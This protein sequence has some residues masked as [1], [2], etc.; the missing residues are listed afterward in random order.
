[1][2]LGIGSDHAGYAA[3]EHLKRWLA[4]RGHD[5]EDVGTHGTA[6]VDYPDYAGQVGRLVAS[7]TVQLGLLICGTGI[8]M[9]IA[10]NKVKG[11]RAAVCTEPFSARFSR[12]H[13][14]AN[15]LCL[16]ARVTG[17]GL[18]EDTL[19]AFLSAGFEAGRHA[20]RVEKI[21]RLENDCGC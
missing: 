21:G 13:N 5:V 17:L 16:G 15:V 14:D 2:K 8:G 9:S 1:M 11:V 12:Q 18:M 10:A 20:N 7:G 19:E 6:S 3:K 4:E